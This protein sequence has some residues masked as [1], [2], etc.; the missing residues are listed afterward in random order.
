MGA[1]KVGVVG[2]GKIA[3]QV[4]LPGLAGSPNAEIHALCDTNETRLNLL[5]ERYHVSPD[6]RFQ[7]YRDLVLLPEIQAVDIATPNFAHFE[8]VVAAYKNGKHV[9]I[10]KPI[11]LNYPQALEMEAHART[12]GVTTMVCFSFRFNAAVRFAKWI[13]DEGCIGKILTVYVQYLKSA[14]FD[15]SRGLEWRFQKDLAGSGVIGDLGSHMVDLISFLAGDI[16]SVCSATGIAVPERRRLDAGGMGR[17]S[18]DDCCSTI[19]S[20]ACGGHASII[21]SRC[22]IAQESENSVKAAVYGDRGMVRFDTEKPSEIAACSGTLDFS[23]NSAHTYPVP[24]SFSAEQMDCFAKN[25]GGDTDRYLPVLGDGVRCQK[26]LDAMIS[27]AE[28]GTRVGV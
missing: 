3:E 23:T 2:L 17:V 15:R 16:T 21:L 19:A 5:G 11:A 18:T 8:P 6:R 10:E 13:I 7:N 4:H 26:I 24:K 25:V 22:A 9:C 27:S 12:S 28:Q 20:L 1:I 14:A